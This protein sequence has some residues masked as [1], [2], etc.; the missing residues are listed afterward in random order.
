[1]VGIPTGQGEDSRIVIVGAGH[2][3]GSVASML[4]QFGHRGPITLVGDQPYPPY[5]RP[6]LSKAYL[7]GESDLETLKLKVDS[8]YIQHDI[9]LRLGSAVEAIEPAEKRIRLASGGHEPYDALILA[10]GSRARRLPLDGADA[11]NVHMLTSIADAEALKAAMGPGRRLAIIGGGYVGLEV[12]ASARLLGA[13]AVII[14]RESRVL[15]RV[16]CEPLSRFFNDYHIARGVEIVPGATI[17]SLERDTHGFVSGLNLADGRHIACDFVLVGIGA[18]PCDELASAAGVACDGGIVVDAHGRTS[19]PDIYAI[20]DTT[21][22]PLPL[23]GNRMVRLESV[24]NALEQGKQVVH[25][26]LGRAAPAP[27]VPWFWSDQYDLKLQIAGVTLDSED[28]LVRGDISAGKFAI[29]HMRGDQ[30]RAVEAVN[31]PQ[32]FMVGRQMIASG[33][34]VSRERLQDV[35]LTMKAIA[36]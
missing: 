2:A 8:F 1:M 24:P 4:R 31:S 17:E 11:P 36:A 13:E 30:V 15:A 16:A 18:S 7:K 5:Q 22:R 10:T 21:R 9:S 27:E 32:E 35:A 23:Y 12:A 20:G 33:R 29:F 34:P 14:E 28:F 3:G 19:D 6:P 26:I 25:A